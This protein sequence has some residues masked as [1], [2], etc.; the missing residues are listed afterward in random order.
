MAEFD[1]SQPQSRMEKILGTIIKSYNGTLDEPQSRVEAYLN[2]VAEVVATK[3]DLD[4]NKRNYS[5][6]IVNSTSDLI[7][8]TLVFRHGSTDEVSSY[9]T[10]N[11]MTVYL[12]TTGLWNVYVDG[13]G[14]KT[15]TANKHSYL[16]RRL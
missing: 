7:G 6:V 1:L 13:I 10:G 12:P 15:F 5:T 3:D 2:E 11:K 9:V 4:T 16:S 14:I 8:K